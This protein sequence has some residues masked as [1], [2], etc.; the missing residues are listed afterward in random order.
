[1]LVKMSPG[2]QAS[3][4]Q[5]H[6]HLPAHL[7][8]VQAADLLT[9]VVDRPDSSVSNPSSSCRIVDLPDPDGPTKAT[10]SPGRHVKRD[11]AQDRRPV[12]GGS[13]TPRAGS[14]CRRRGR[15][16]RTCP[17]APRAA[18]PGWAW[19]AR[20]SEI[21]LSVT[22]SAAGATSTADRHAANA[23]PKARKS[24]VR[25]A[26]SSASQQGQRRPEDER[27]RGQHR[28]RRGE[29]GQPV[30]VEPRLVLQP[31]LLGEAV[32]PLR[33]GARLGAGH[34]QLADAGQAAGARG[35]RS[36]PAASVALRSGRVWT[37]RRRRS[38][39]PRR[40]IRM[41][42]AAPSSGCNRTSGEVARGAKMPPRMA[43]TVDARERL[44][45]GVD[46]HARG[47]ARSPAV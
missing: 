15:P 17:P 6:A 9:V 23:A 13:G 2:D 46:R 45:D 29:G 41:A 34:A 11:V 12:A 39:R 1:M 35:P 20:N 7:L 32:H 44:L 25:S 33:E 5:H 47:L 4:L 38:P 19:P 16:D 40:R 18:S 21:V 3:V 31:A 27:G 22:S 30:R 24:P 28:E 42:T 37:G 26:G 36:S 8:D 43:V 10:N 14:R